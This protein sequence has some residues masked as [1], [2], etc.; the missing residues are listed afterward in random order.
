MILRR[1]EKINSKLLIRFMSG[2]NLS[3]S[4]GIHQVSERFSEESR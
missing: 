2:V 4:G 1:E 3:T